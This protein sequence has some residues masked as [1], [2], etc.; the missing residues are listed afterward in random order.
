MGGVFHD[1]LVGD[2]VVLPPGA[3]PEAGEAVVRL[4]GSYL[5]YDHAASVAPERPTRGAVGLP[6]QGFVFCSFNTSK[7]FEPRIWDVW[8]RL[9]RQV[10]GSVLWLTELDQEY[11]EALLAEAAALGVDGERL[12]LAPQLPLDRHLARCGLADLF[13]DTPLYNAHT[14]AG[15]SLF[16]GVPVLTTSTGGCFHTRVAHSL[17]SAIGLPELAVRDLDRYEERALELAREPELL[18]DLRRRVAQNARELPPFDGPAFVRRLESA[19]LEMWRRY[20][21]G[22]GPSGF[23]V[24]RD[25]SIETGGI[26]E[27]VVMPERAMAAAGNQTST[28]ARPE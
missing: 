2:P 13:L 18:A 23:S 27:P 20:Q 28:G 25:G 5:I 17:V 12:V 16:T 8:M 6:D 11:R 21:D 10:P 9:L 15:H 24:Q 19:Y 22:R 3:D 4:H 26:G 1:Y 14:T 7:K